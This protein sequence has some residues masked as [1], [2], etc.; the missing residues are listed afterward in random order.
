M[1]VFL[2]LYAL[3]WRCFFLAHAREVC[4]GCQHFQHMF[5]PF[6]INTLRCGN[7]VISVMNVLECV[8]KFFGFQHLPTHSTPFPTHLF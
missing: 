5:Y 4:F 3:G 2:R 8:G 7:E 1:I 6:D